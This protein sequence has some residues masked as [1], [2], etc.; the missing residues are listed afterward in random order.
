MTR[1]QLSAD[2]LG[3]MKQ[4]LSAE[5]AE[6]GREARRKVELLD[7]QLAEL[8]QKKRRI[9]EM[10]EDG[11]YSKEEFLERKTAVESE[12]NQTRLERHE[13]DTQ[14]PDLETVFYYAQQFVKRFGDNWERMPEDVAREFQKIVFPDGIEYRRDEGFGTPKP[15][16]IFNAVHNFFLNQSPK[17]G[18]LGFEPR[19]TRTRIVYVTVTLCPGVKFRRARRECYRYTTFRLIFL[20]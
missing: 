8:E 2:H 13:C 7:R 10:R 12:I 14:I 11:S 6:V 15:G 5:L 16:P 4:L 19:V 20:L 3:K 1:Y 17:V 9:Y 18:T